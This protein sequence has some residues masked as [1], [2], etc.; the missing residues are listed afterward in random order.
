MN[1]KAYTPD[2][3]NGVM[4]SISTIT[5]M[6]NRKDDKEY[7]QGLKDAIIALTN[8]YKYDDDDGYFS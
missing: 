7:N 4:D 8:L 6:I 2:Y 1:D 3:I 5:S